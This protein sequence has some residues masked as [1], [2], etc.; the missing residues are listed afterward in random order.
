MRSFRSLR[1]ILYIYIVCLCAVTITARRAVDQ[2]SLDA[3][4]QMKMLSLLLIA[5]LGFNASPSSFKG[6]EIVE[7]TINRLQACT[8]AML[9]T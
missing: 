6:A 7:I 5:T 3:A 2:L 8:Q 1:C 4:K 9:Y